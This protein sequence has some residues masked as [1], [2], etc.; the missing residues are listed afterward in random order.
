MKVKYININGY[1]VDVG[2]EMQVNAIC[3]M[4]LTKS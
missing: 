4:K 2:N 3:K 1:V